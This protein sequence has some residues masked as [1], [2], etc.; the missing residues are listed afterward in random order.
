[1]CR[2]GPPTPTSRQEPAKPP[3]PAGSWFG[4]GVPSQA[5]S[6]LRRHSTP[7]SLAPITVWGV[8]GGS[9]VL[10]GS[11]TQ[12]Q[13]GSRLTRDPG[14]HTGANCPL[15]HNCCSQP[16]WGAGGL[17]SDSA[18]GGPAPVE[19][20]TAR[21]LPSQASLGGQSPE[22]LS[23]AA[24]TR[25]ARAREEWLVQERGRGQ[26]ESQWLCASPGQ[27]QGDGY[28]TRSIYWQQ[29]RLGRAGTQQSQHQGKTHRG[30]TKAKKKR[31]CEQPLHG[32]RNASPAS[33]GS[34]L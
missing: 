34:L 32:A 30:K 22:P 17:G 16:L 23:Q 26:R 33:S 27:R 21:A 18:Q 15:T 1:M 12:R 6:A 9:T 20:G 31:H 19:L 2:Q 24:S 5:S 8:V 28:K 10:L 25:Q 13:A 11:H 7:R 4:N 14:D 29:S 3:C